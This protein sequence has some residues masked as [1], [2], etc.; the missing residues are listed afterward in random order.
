MS[1]RII[2]AV[3]Q[4]KGFPGAAPEHGEPDQWHIYASTSPKSKTSKF[5]TLLVPFKKN[6]KP[7]IKVNNLV[8]KPDEVSLELRI[9]GLLSCINQLNV[10]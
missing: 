7:Q 10:F 6:E 2:L 3:K 1:E 5:I 8:E 9:G 4:I